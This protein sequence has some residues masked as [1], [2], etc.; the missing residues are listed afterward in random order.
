MVSEE[1]PTVKVKQ[2]TVTA[3]TNNRCQTNSNIKLEEPTVK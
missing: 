3:A 1:E 2:L